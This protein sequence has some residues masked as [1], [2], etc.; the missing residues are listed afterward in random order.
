MDAKNRNPFSQP[1]LS[2][3]DQ[4]GEPDALILGL[5]AKKPVGRE[6]SS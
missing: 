4:R 1:D 3:I 5:R 2:R 6:L